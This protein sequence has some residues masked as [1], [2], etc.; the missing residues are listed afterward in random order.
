MAET[1]NKLMLVLGY[2]KYVAQGGDWGSFIARRLAQLYPQ[3]CKAIHLNMLYSEPPKITRGPLIWLKWVT[4]LGPL[5]LY[6]KREIQG[7]KNIKRY[8]DLDSGYYVFPRNLRHALMEDGPV[9]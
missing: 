3:N 4:L 1:F 5:F 6:D 8:W 9:D 7:L 2:S